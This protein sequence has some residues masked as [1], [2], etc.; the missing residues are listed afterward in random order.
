MS[1]IVSFYNQM[2]SGNQLLHASDHMQQ[3]LNQT[4]PLQEVS[5]LNLLSNQQALS[6]QV[7]SCY[8]RRISPGGALERTN[9]SAQKSMQDCFTT[10]EAC[11]EVVLQKFYSGKSSVAAQT[12]FVS[13]GSLVQPVPAKHESDKDSDH[14]SS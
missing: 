9:H 11:I 3:Q 7:M 8:K 12:A 13:D 2:L 4:S 5:Q 1:S 14:K 10:L 6:H